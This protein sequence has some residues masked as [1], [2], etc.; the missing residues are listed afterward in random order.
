[1]RKV[2]SHTHYVT[3]VMSED[4]SGITADNS[5]HPEFGH[6]GGHPDT[7]TTI[8]ARFGVKAPAP[9]AAPKAKKADD[10]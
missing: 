8:G 10:E 5:M 1:M 9:K 7:V 6:A 4:E 2:T 3:G